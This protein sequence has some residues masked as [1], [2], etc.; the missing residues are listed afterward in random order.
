[1]LLKEYI[2]AEKPYHFFQEINSTIVNLVETADEF[3]YM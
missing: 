2:L 3:I 1:M